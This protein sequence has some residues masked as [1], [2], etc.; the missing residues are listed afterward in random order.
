MH[1][2]LHTIGYSTGDYSARAFPAVPAKG[3]RHADRVL[4]HRAESGPDRYDVQQHD[5]SGLAGAEFDVRKKSDS[6][7]VEHLTTDAEGN[8][9]VAGLPFG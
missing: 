4:G 3:R 6:S 1:T 5:G 7:L 9:C 8:A 2:A